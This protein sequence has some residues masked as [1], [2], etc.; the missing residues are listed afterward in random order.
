MLKGSVT[1]PLTEWSLKKWDTYHNLQAPVIRVRIDPADIAGERG[2]FGPVLFLPYTLPQSEEAPA[3]MRLLSLEGW[4]G[5]GT[6]SETSARLL[7]PTQIVW[8][9]NRSR[10]QVPLTDVQIEAIGQLRNGSLVNLV[11]WLG[12]WASVGQVVEPVQSPSPGHLPIAREHWLTILQQLGAG[13]RR[14][15]ELPEPHLPRGIQQWAECMRLLDQATQL[16]RSGAYEYVLVNCREIVEG[17]LRE[18][19][20][21]WGLTLQGRNFR[22]RAQSLRDQLSTAWPEDRWTPETLQFLLAGAW[23]WLAPTPHYGTGI[24]QREEAAFALGLC[25]DLLLFAGLLISDQTCDSSSSCAFSSGL[26]SL[27]DTSSWMDPV[28]GVQ[29]RWGDTSN[30]RTGRVRLDWG[31]QNLWARGVRVD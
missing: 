21:V 2:T 8:P 13:A 5:C 23:R 17:I 19:C 24:P 27:S 11:V 6:E 29:T 26:S 10:L 3:S 15:V 31:S 22:E 20:S 7:I 14:L 1:M 25:T 30:S 9:D 4:V 18:L 12:G 16:H 28:D